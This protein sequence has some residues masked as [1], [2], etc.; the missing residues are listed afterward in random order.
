MKKFL[1]GALLG[2]PLFVFCARVENERP[3]KPFVMPMLKEE[4]ERAK[5]KEVRSVIVEDMDAFIKAVGEEKIRT[6]AYWRLE[7]DSGMYERGT[8]VF[9]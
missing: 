2:L 5:V 6:K 7:W 1:R 4:L 9:D 8:F 3:V